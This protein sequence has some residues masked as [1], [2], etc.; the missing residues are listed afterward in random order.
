MRMFHQKIKDIQYSITR[1]PK[2]INNFSN[3]ESLVIQKIGEFIYD[4]DNIYLATN[5]RKLWDYSSVHNLE[6]YLEIIKKLHN[7]NLLDLKL[8]DDTVF[9]SVI[10]FPDLM[11]I[12]YKNFLIDFKKVVDSIIFQI[13]VNKETDSF[14]IAENVKVKLVVVNNI[15]DYLRKNGVL[16]LMRYSGTPLPGGKS[17]IILKF[18]ET[19]IDSVY[20]LILNT[21]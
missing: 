13:K 19:K 5:I 8:L 3:D 10:I 21:I 7:K 14:K 11:V 2:G 4:T 20:D 17:F 16:E 15:L 1:E 6:E 18:D 12:Y 9:S